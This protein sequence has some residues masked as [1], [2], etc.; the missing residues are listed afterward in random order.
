MTN[1]LAPEIIWFTPS[2]SYFKDPISTFRAVSKAASARGLL[3]L[4]VDVLLK[5]KARLLT[6]GLV[7]TMASTN[8]THLLGSGCWVGLVQTSTTPPSL[9]TAFF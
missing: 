5:C 4:V 6:M 3:G 8:K 7:F 9:L 2:E 1:P